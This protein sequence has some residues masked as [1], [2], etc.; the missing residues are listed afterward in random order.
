MTINHFPVL[1]GIVYFLPVAQAFG[2]LFRV[3]LL[4]GAV[5]LVPLAQLLLRL[6]DLRLFDLRPQR[7]VLGLLVR[8]GLGELLGL[9]GLGGLRLAA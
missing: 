3:L 6:F 5:G 9:L 7:R 4:K 2:S 1:D 8:Q